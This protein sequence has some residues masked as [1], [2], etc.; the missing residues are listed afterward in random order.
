MFC[1]FVSDVFAALQNMTRGKAK[2]KAGV[3]LEMI[4]KSREEAHKCL[5]KL[6]DGMLDFGR[7]PEEWQETFFVV[8]PK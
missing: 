2:D 1:L 4:A 8:L 6:R 3:A 7:I 5:I